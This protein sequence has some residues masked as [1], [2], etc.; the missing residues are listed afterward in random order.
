M[1]IFT[2]IWQVAEGANFKPLLGY[3]V[4]DNN[5]DS[6]TRRLGAGSRLRIGAYAENK[7]TE[8]Y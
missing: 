3:K 7:Q 6:A 8:K 2:H 1:Q 5:E 4:E